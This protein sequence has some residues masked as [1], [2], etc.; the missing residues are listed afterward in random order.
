MLYYSQRVTGVWLMSGFEYKVH[1]SLGAYLH[2]KGL[3]R[4]RYR[5]VNIEKYFEN[6]TVDESEYWIE[7]K[8][9]RADVKY[10]FKRG[11]R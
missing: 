3:N 9:R 7:V 2:H 4:V 8:R 1:D 5:L 6:D 10:G 11:S